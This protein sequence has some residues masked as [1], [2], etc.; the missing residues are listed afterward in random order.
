MSVAIVQ[1]GIANTASLLAAFQRQGVEAK[2]CNAA[3]EIISAAHLVLPGVGSFGAG[4]ELLSSGGLVEPLRS[5]VL[6]GKPTLSV[7]LGMHLLCEKSEESPGVAGLG[8][9]PIEVKRFS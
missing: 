4:M 1:T 8:I 5:R 3:A 7:C 6:E 2:L 9:F